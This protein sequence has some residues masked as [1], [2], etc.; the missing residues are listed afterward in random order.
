MWWVVISRPVLLFGSVQVILLAM[1]G[2]TY[3]AGRV[4]WAFF[5]SV[6]RFSLAYILGLLQF[7]FSYLYCNF[8]IFFLLFFQ[9]SYLLKSVHS[10][11]FICLF[12]FL[13]Q[14]SFFLLFLFPTSLSSHPGI[15]LP[16]W[17]LPTFP[18]AFSSFPSFL[19]FH[20]PF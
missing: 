13:F 18:A 11:P 6:F 2:C 12:F 15:G 16:I 19:F 8:L 5:W 7:G 10:V 4:Y 9:H 14:F 20:I 3:W 1:L 17:P